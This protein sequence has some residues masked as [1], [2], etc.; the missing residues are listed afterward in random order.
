MWAGV[1]RSSSESRKGQV[2]DLLAEYRSSSA[3]S[4]SVAETIM[5]EGLLKEA[6]SLASEVVRASSSA[7]SGA[8]GVHLVSDR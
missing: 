3:T 4:E 5:F 6:A 7:M 8:Q 2:V 1:D